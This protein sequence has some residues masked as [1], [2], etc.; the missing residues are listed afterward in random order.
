M[1]SY[2]NG[3]IPS[4]LLAP[5]FAPS[6][7]SYYTRNIMDLD[8]FLQAH[9]CDPSYAPLISAWRTLAPQAACTAP[10]PEALDVR[11][12]TAL[13]E[14][15]V[16]RLYSHQAEAIERSFAGEN[17]VVVTPTASGKTIC[18]NLPVLQRLL[19]EPGA[20]AI[21]LFPTKALAHDQLE[22]LNALGTHLGLGAFATAYDGD[23]PRG[24][25]PRIRR[26][27]R[28]IVTNPDMLHVGILP[29]HV[30]WAEFLRRLRYV[31]IDEMHA[32]RGVFG[33]HVANVLR[34]LRRIC[35]FYGSE[36]QYICS[37]ATI[38]NPGQLATQ[39]LDRPTGLIERNGA[40]RGE[41][42]LILLDPPLLDERLGRRMPALRQAEALCH[43]LLAADIQTVVFCRSRREVERLVVALRQEAARLDLPPECI[44]GYRS[45]YLPD[46]RRAVESGLRSRTVRMVVATTALEL[47]IDIGGLAACVMVG[48]PGTIASTWQQVGRAGRGLETSA[49]WLI[50]GESP[51]DQYVVGHPEY[52][53]GR[54]HEHALIN[55]DN[56]YLL[57]GHVPCALAELPFQDGESYGHERLEE[58][59]AYLEETGQARHAGKQWLSASTGHPAGE[60]ALRSA[61]PHSVAIYCKDA[62]GR[63][64]IGRLDRASAPLWVHEGAIY[65]HEGDQYAVRSL[66]WEEGVA[67]VEPAQVSHYT[68]ASRSTRIAIERVWEQRSQSG[69][70]LTLGEV[71]QTTRWTGYRQIDL[72]TQ[73]FR[74]WAPIDLPEQ[75]LVA[76]ACWLT[77]EETL[78]DRLKAEGRW[79]GERVESRGPNW[80]EQRDRARERDGHRCRWCGADEVARPHHVHHIRPFREFRWLPGRNDN[81]RLANELDNLITLCPSC[82]RQAEQQVAV[83]STLGGVARLLGHVI[84][85]QLMCDPRDIGLQSELKAPATKR[86]TLFVLERVPG[87]IGLSDEVFRRFEDLLAQALE[88][89]RDCGCENGCPACIGADTGNDSNAKSQVVR[90]LRELLG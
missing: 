17:V 61:D 79:T 6:P 81:Y 34:R 39:L 49:A 75:E 70:Q 80:E 89:V 88:W 77:L 22:G 64:E 46:E 36:P 12:R 60:I 66:D 33:S 26:E 8:R 24:A 31:I 44:R 15:G 65:M 83:Q 40:P 32:Y 9:K 55:P 59:L 69:G 90:L 41:R 54:A 84:P 45:G 56:L 37:S 76:A 47:G 68:E 62:Q 42:H 86:P 52:L 87:G 35:R 73:A 38:A 30:S 67:L 58:M 10:F 21:Y 7:S 29:G 1:S 82:H 28:L 20:R 5:P 25:R 16:E 3:M 4:Y 50:A 85:L 53:L 63:R 14:L 27:A 71:L 43:K 57:L 19:R 11:L 74:G 23:T 2:G 51:L 72:H 18:Y 48:Y 13:S 78:I